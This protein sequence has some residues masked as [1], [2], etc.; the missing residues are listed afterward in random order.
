MMP[1]LFYA[2]IGWIAACLPSYR[3]SRIYRG[4]DG[5]VPYMLFAAFSA[6]HDDADFVARVRKILDK[7]GDDRQAL[8]RIAAALTISAM[9]ASTRASEVT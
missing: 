6:R 3:Y 8:Q 1:P 7:H 9:D 2:I 5:N 4:G